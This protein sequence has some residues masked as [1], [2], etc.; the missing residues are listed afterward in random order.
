[1]PFADALRNNTNMFY[2]DLKDNEI[3]NECAN[4]LITLLRK[5]YF[6][7]DLVLEGNLHINHNYK[8]TIIE[9]CRQNLLIK[10]FILPY[11]DKKEV[12]GV[13]HYDT[14][15]L[16]LQ[17]MSFFRSDFIAKFVGMNR[18]EFRELS[19][20][21]VHFDEH[22]K[23]LADFLKKEHTQIA[24]IVLHDCAIG[25]TQICRMIADCRHI[26]TLRELRLLRMNMR[27]HT[28]EIIQSLHDHRQL[29]ILDLTD[30]GIQSMDYISRFL[31]YNQVIRELVLAGNPPLSVK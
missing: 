4:K 17:D 1:M 2:L 29:R 28:N 9:E 26:T 27:A 7:E 6:I 15:S 23:C 30:N 14:A 18:Y 25:D 13:E 19:L 3:D 12:D 8:E 22:I 31:S 21:R 24:S 16:R 20:T 10:E 5:N 11:L